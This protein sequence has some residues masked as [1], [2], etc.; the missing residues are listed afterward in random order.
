MS[1]YKRLQITTKDGEIIDRRTRNHYTHAATN[2]FNATFHTRK[3]LAEK[4]ASAKRSR[5][6]AWYVVPIDNPFERDKTAEVG[7]PMAKY[8]PRIEVEKVETYDMILIE[9]VSNGYNSRT[10][11]MDN[12]VFEARGFGVVMRRD[13]VEEVRATID[14]KR[15][16]RS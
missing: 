8:P 14:R 9:K 10:G 16:E 6:G 4:S 7:V 2:G 11:R 1:E 12:V 5:G 3:D 15:A 13:T